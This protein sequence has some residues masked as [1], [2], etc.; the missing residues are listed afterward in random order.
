MCLCVCRYEFGTRG[1]EAADELLRW[2][3]YRETAQD[4]SWQDPEEVSRKKIEM[5]KLAEQL[6]KDL[7]AKNRENEAQAD[8]IKD[9]ESRLSKL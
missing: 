3:G 7:D 8:R 1:P 4:F 2:A 5:G 6:Q 9:L